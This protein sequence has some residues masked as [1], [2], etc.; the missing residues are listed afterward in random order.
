MADKTDYYLQTLNMIGAPLMG[1]ALHHG[2]GKNAAEV[3]QV[4][5]ALLGKSVQSS[6][7]LGPLVDLDKLGE[8]ADNVRVALAGLSAQMLAD[9]YTDQGKL[10]ED[11][12]VATIK[13]GL[14]AVIGFADNFQPSAEAA[15]RL[16]GVEAGAVAPDIVQ[17]QVQYLHAFTSLVQS[18]HEF[19]FG[20]P[21]P[22]LMGQI[23]QKLGQK[24]SALRSDHF[25]DQG[26]AEQQNMQE[27]AF[28]AALGR[29]YSAC[30]IKVVKAIDPQ[31][32]DQ[33]PP[34]IDDV[35][36]QFDEQYQILSVL[37]SSLA[38]G[39]VPETT[40]PAPEAL[41]ETGP[42]AAAAPPA[43]A[44]AA[45]PAAE[46]PSAPATP[47]TDASSSDSSGGGGPMGFFAKKP[48]SA[49][50]TAP[51]A[52]SDVTPPPAPPPEVPASPQAQEVP[53]PAPAEAPASAPPEVPQAP[54]SPPSPP[55]SQEPPAAGGSPMG[56]FAK[57]PDAAGETAPA[58]PATTPPVTP[59]A[60]PP[61][62]SPAE[63]GDKPADSG[64][65]MA[66]FSKKNED[67]E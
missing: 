67:D 51:A 63:N 36:E 31:N 32:T 27:L 54:V 44:E 14:Q 24:A 22:Q 34:K 23:A 55:A 52:P 33:A 62:T 26:S 2:G 66:F 48:D 5:A 53:P 18:V 21:A 42:V 12:D 6:I 3:A 58:T 41:P 65:P 49:G 64:N 17:S 19:S 50:D 20:Q 9:Y 35:W 38:S 46:A 25:G 11:A 28:L 56:F 61:I 40:P 13:D 15:L 8:G 45:P 16:Q 1:A 4:V 30:H 10:P 29:L 39:A 57:K 47:P 43:Q 59:P 60:Q 7:A 37:V